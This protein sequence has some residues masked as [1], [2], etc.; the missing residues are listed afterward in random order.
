MSTYPTDEDFLVEVESALEKS[1]LPEPGVAVL[2]R[3]RDA[4]MGAVY[5]LVA[6]LRKPHPAV[7]SAPAERCGDVLT[8][9]LGGESTECVLRPGHQ[10]SHADEAGTRWRL[11][12]PSAPADRDAVLREAAGQYERLLADIGADTVQDPRYWTG[13]HH[14]IT[15]LRRMADEA[16]QS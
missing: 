11:T 1:L 6:E 8:P 15:G 4:V 7:P 12:T 10:G 2:E 5:P 9:V 3:A 14:V 13:V 16:Q